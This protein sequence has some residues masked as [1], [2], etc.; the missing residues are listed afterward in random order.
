MHIYTHV[1]VHHTHVPIHNRNNQMCSRGAI[2]APRSILLTTKIVQLVKCVP[3]KRG[4]PCKTLRH[5]ATCCSPR[6]E[7]AE[8]DRFMGNLPD[9]LA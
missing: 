2:R 8:T 6:T 5:G 1:C 9:S 4:D 7:K 3:R